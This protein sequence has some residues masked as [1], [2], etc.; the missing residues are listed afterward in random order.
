MLLA[1]AFYTQ[2]IISYQFT[3]INLSV[4]TQHKLQCKYF[5]SLVSTLHLVFVLSLLKYFPLIN[6]PFHYWWCLHW[7]I[8][9]IPWLFCYGCN[10]ISKCVLSHWRKTLKIV[11]FWWTFVL[12]GSHPPLLSTQLGSNFLIFLCLMSLFWKTFLFHVTH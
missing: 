1:S 10:H 12:S 9:F 3:A 4:N 8:C 5:L 6:F 11:I 2:A 7:V